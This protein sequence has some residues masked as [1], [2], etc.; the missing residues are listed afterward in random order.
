MP[1]RCKID[2]GVVD[3]PRRLGVLFFYTF[4]AQ[5][6]N[7]ETSPFPRFLRL[8]RC[9]LFPVTLDL[10]VRPSLFRPLLDSGGSDGERRIAPLEEFRPIHFVQ[11][12]R[13]LHFQNFEIR[14]CVYKYFKSIPSEV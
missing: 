12:I 11:D 4:R 6:R 8:L 7:N 5:H 10:P 14:F 2:A 1:F 3:A 13:V 9:S